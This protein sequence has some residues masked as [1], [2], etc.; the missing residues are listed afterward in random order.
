M[1][2]GDH[3]VCTTITEFPGGEKSPRL[4]TNPFYGS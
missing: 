4:F 3:Q 1:S 2:G